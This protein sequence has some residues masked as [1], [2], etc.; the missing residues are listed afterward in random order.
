[1]RVLWPAALAAWGA[2]VC[3]E[4]YTEDLLV[5]PLADG[6]ALLHFDFEMQTDNGSTHSYHVFPR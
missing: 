3:A 4:T 1:M 2:A 6:R 5:A